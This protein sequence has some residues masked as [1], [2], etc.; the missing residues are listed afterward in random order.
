MQS[1]A[2]GNRFFV[3]LR[4]GLAQSQ[5][6]NRILA[7]QRLIPRTQAMT[8]NI[9]KFWLNFALGALL[10]NFGRPAG[11]EPTWRLDAPVHMASRDGELRTRRRDSNTFPQAS[12]I[13][14][15]H[16]SQLFVRFGV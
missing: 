11:G 10:V 3:E 7:Y 5:L 2:T 9:A 14:V 13:A 15:S 8:L 1:V 6:L 16:G 4:S 12:Q